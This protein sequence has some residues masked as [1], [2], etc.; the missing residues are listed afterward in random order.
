MTKEEFIV[1]SVGIVQWE[2]YAAR[3]D[4]MDCF[5]LIVMYYQH[6][7]SIDVSTELKSL[8]LWKEAGWI[9]IDEPSEHSCMFMSWQYG[10]PTHC[11]VY[12]GDGKVLHCDGSDT[13]NGGVRVNSVQSINN[14]F[15]DMKFYAYN[16]S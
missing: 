6:V 13:R 14:I 12:I 11:G 5:G 4:A 1:R 3:W 7:L 8:S 16:P 9:E 2:K 10:S 15:G